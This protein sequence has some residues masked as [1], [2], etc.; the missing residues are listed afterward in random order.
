MKK[1]KAA[2]RAKGSGS[3]NEYE[4]FRKLARISGVKKKGLKKD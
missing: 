3:L 1:P 4:A 2:R